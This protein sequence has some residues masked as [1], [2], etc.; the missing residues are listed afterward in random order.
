[1]IFRHGAGK[2]NGGGTTGRRRPRRSGLP[3]AKQRR[4]RWRGGGCEAW[5]G[6]SRRGGAA[7]TRRCGGERRWR[8]KTFGRARLAGRRQKGKNGRGGAI[9]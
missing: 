6:S 1:M 5:R 3:R 9:L 7:G 2:H 4:G 8:G